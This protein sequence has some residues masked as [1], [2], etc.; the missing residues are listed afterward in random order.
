MEE[1]EEDEEEERRKRRRREDGDEEDE[2]D[3]EE[4]KDLEEKG[5]KPVNIEAAPAVSVSHQLHVF[6]SKRRFLSRINPH[7]YR[8]FPPAD[9]HPD[10]SSVS[11]GHKPC[12]THTDRPAAPRP[13]PPAS[14]VFTAQSR[15]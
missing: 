6:P 5:G 12:L 15:S 3:E 4:E 8:M 11:H 10:N 2:R 7:P 14:P 1:E 9:F 13:N